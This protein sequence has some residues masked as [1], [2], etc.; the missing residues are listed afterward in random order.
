M[1]VLNKNK[2]NES[3]LCVCVCV[4]LHPQVRGQVLAEDLSFRAAALSKL[5]VCV[6]MGGGNAAVEGEGLGAANCRWGGG[7]GGLEGEGLGGRGAGSGRQP[8]TGG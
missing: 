5:Q 6:G 8:E 4:C 7:T 1:C 2:R 3:P